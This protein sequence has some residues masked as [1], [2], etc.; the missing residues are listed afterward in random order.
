MPA[1]PVHPPPSPTPNANPPNFSPLLAPLL[2]HPRDVPA[3][4]AVTLFFMNPA[5]TAVAAWVFLSE[6]LG[7]KGLAGVFMS[8][9]GL[10]VLSQPPFIFDPHGEV[11]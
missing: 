8:L 6:P 11:S 1:A 9:I 2:C 4:D 3:A 5:V 10:V 7:L